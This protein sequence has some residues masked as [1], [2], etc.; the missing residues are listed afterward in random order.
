MDFL[1]AALGSALLLAAIW[2]GSALAV[3]FIARARGGNLLHWSAYGFF[4]G[5]VGLLLLMRMVHPCPHC[6]AKVLRGVK[7]CPSCQQSIPPLDPE[8]NPVGSFWSYR[9]N[10]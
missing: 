3:P 8:R 5:P 10:W 1:T 2:L 7:T 6:R 9:R 4:L